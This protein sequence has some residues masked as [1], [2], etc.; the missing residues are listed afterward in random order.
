[1]ATPSSHAA[2]SVGA[3]K[4]RRYNETPARQRR[5]VAGDFI[6]LGEQVWKGGFGACF[7]GDHARAQEGGGEAREA[8][9]SS[10]PRE[11]PG[12]AEW[13]LK[14]ALTYAG[15]DPLQVQSGSQA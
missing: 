1:M 13:A 4:G 9:R 6:G 7:S 12:G 3:A 5:S 11:C 8:P 10:K 14:M 2:V 15:Q